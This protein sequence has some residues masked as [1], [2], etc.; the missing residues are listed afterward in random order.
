MS[1][2]SKRTTIARKYSATEMVALAVDASV[3]RA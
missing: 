1:D 3:P 2:F